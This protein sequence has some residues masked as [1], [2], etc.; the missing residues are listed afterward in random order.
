[1]S[2]ETYEQAR[3]D[4]PEAAL[5]WIVEQG[6]LEP[7][8]TVVDVAAGTGKLTRQLVARGL[9]VV[10]VE[11]IG[12]MLEVLRRVLPEVETFEAVAEDLPLADGSADAITVGQAFHWFDQEQVVPEFHR[13]LKPGGVV[14]LVWNVRDESDPL[15]AAY[16]ALLRP[17]RGSDYPE[18][19]WTAPLE[20]SEL[21]DVERRDFAHSQ[22]MDADALVARA[23][24]V[25]FVA[26][27][28][29]EERDALLD[30]VHRL[31]PPGDFAFPYLTKVFTG[32]SR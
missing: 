26:Q 8:D 2:A 29:D 3:P 15:Q 17:H 25:S 24:S 28:P 14:A 22:V 21:F 32:R 7:G 30:R 5:G 4:Y 16:A 27:L 12:E 1:L 20:E 23:A 19:P 9:R 31:A 10:A 11:P 6:R 13:V 18:P